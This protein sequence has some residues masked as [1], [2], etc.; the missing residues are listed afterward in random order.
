MARTSDLDRVTAIVLRFMRGPILL[1]VAVYG[2]G[3]TGMVLIPGQD[4]EGNPTHMGFFHAFYFMSYTATTTGFG[5]I[6]NEFNDAQRMWVVVCLYMSVTAWIYAIGSIISLIQNPYFKQ[7]M[8]QKRFSLLVERIS[9]PFIIIAGFGDTGSLLA[10]GLSEQ[11]MTAVVIDADPERIKALRLRDYRV[12]MPGLCGDPGVP[13]TLLDA[14]LRHARCQAVVALTSDGALNLKIAVLVRLLNPEVKII[15]RSTSPALE[16]EMQ[17]L[18]MV[19]VVNPFQIFADGLYTALNLPALYTLDQ[20]LVRARGIAL[21]GPT[22]CPKGTWILCGFGRMGQHIYASLREH[23]LQTVV[24]D[25]DLESV[26]GV[27]DK[28]VGNANHKTLLEAGIKEAAGVVAATD[29]DPIN[30]QILIAA[31]A[32]NPGIFMAVRQNQHENEPAFQ[33]GRADLIMQPSLATARRI[34]L[35]LVSPFIQIFLEHLRHH[36]SPLLDD[37]VARLKETVGD[38]DVYLWTTKINQVEAAAV[39][40]L[41]GRSQ[42]ISLADLIR[43][44]DDR[45]DTLKCLPLV[46]HRAQ[47]SVAIPNPHET[48]IATGDELLFCGTR[49][50]QRLLDATLHNAY[51]LEYLTTGVERPRGL[52]MKRFYRWSTQRKPELPHG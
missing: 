17:F 13:K 32:L 42:R 20:W 45:T 26:D 36:G 18:D 48:C 30:L 38:A 9:E 41:L 5:E 51:T 6:P 15:C 19:E 35:Q 52:L 34:L 2:I 39:C 25:P 1:L 50:S 46:L 29:S 22:N 24:I 11:N 49:H 4:A 8:A 43:N 44:P 47:E 28:I 16:E 12:R 37:I 27:V 21:E 40:A 31:R 3:I 14:G 10:R 23:G 33:A 7:A